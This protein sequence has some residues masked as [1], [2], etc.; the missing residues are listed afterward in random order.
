VDDRVSGFTYDSLGNQTSSIENY[1]NGTITPNSDDTIPNATTGA[2]TDL[3]TA[4]AYDTAGNQVSVA[5]P[6]RAIGLASTTYA[7]D[8]F[9]R[10]VT[11]AWGTADTG[12]TW[13]G[14]DATFD[15]GSGIGTITQTSNQAK[16][17]YLTSVSAQDQEA[18]VKVRVD[19]LAVGSDHLVWIYLR[20]QDSNN[21]YQARL[22]F[23]TSGSI[24]AYFSRTAS[25]TTTVIDAGTS[26]VPHTTS[27][28]YWIRARIAGT[29]SV[30]GK[31]KVW[32]D[33]TTEPAGW[34]A[35]GTDATPP[36]NLRGSG[37]TGIRF[38]LGGSYSGSYPVVASFDEFSLTSL[39]GGGAAIGPDDY[40]SRSTFDPLNEQVSDTTPTTPGVTITQHTATTTYDELGQVRSAADYD[41]LISATEYDRAGRATRTFEDPDPAGSAS[42]TS[43]TTYDA[44]GKTLTSEDRSQAADAN[45]GSTTT[46][47]DGLGRVDTVTSADGSSPDVASD[48]KTT[49]DGLDRTTS[50]EVGYGSASSQKTVY[51]YDL[52]GRT[53]TTDDGFACATATFDYRGLI[54]T[55]TDGLVG[56]TCASGANTRTV[57]NSFDGLG[58][59]YRAEVTAGADT[60]DRPTDLTLDSAGNQ[61]TAAVKKAGVTTTTTFT[62]NLLDQVMTEAR[63]DGSTAKT[64]YDPAGNGADR[65]YWAP[66]VTVGSC[67]EVGHAGWTNPPTSST[68]TTSDARNQRIGLVDSATNETTTYDPDHLY[69]VAAIYTPTIADLTREHQT[70]FS[71]DSRH[72]LTGIT[73]QLCVVST[74][75]NCSSTT[76]TGSDTYLY[77]DNNN[78]TKVVE[79]NGATSS[80]R[81]YC[82]DALNQLVYRNTGAACSAGA[83]DEAWTYDDAGNRLTAKTGGV[84]TNFAYTA[85]GLLCDVETAP[86]AASC[87]GGNVTSDS[88]GRIS[89]YAGWTY[90]Y[91]AEGRLVS[92]CKSPTCASGYDKVI[93]AYDGEGHRT[94]IVETAAGG[95]VTTTD[96]RYQ[97]DAVVEESVNGSVARQFTVDGS[98]RIVTMT[99]PSGGSAGTYI[100]TWNGHGDAMALWQENAD[101]SITLANSLTY[102]TWGNPT[103][104]VAGGFSDLGFRYQYVGA[105]DVQW[106]NAYGLGLLYM[107]ARHESPALGR[108]VEPD[109]TRAESNLFA[110]TA[111]AP[112]ARADPAGT[113]FDYYTMNSQ[114]D[115]ICRR[116]WQ[117]CYVDY[118]DGFDAWVVAH[119]LFKDR[120]DL[121]DGN[122][123]AL[124]HCTWQCLLTLDLGAARAEEWGNAHE[125]GA[126]NNERLSRLMDLHNNRVGRWLGSQLPQAQY[127]VRKKVAIRWCVQA[128]QRGYLRIIRRLPRSGGRLVPSTG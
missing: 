46:A 59:Q 80:D 98:G 120:R 9:G 35:D 1:V 91:D 69:Q 122:G 107:H 52:G 12:G 33:G 27:D 45:L 21:Y 94:K 109:P 39:G 41:A 36:A 77:D 117:A 65:C 18:L 28:W 54:L 100:V 23:N 32:R 83:N 57:T 68:S 13:S 102:G 123:D 62:V 10:T 121:T 124:R 90:G 103:T 88:A 92:A 56:G 74:G 127:S 40:V 75:H 42:V 51:G 22:S 24:T 44:D 47:Y 2:R 8:A 66:S 118:R 58:R 81:R 99:I 38:Q 43:V 87:T 108:F 86:T 50:T 31:V 53:L 63:A 128:M 15:V 60:G 55:A 76:A 125:D 101:G 70:L 114:E 97:G 16:S 3:T 105:S 11:D 7:R 116:D 111:N 106:D 82:Y 119:A 64:T 19:H 5:D 115:A 30:N 93:F 20:R 78:R 14:T 110:Y 26:S 48:T 79:D 61:L 37:H 95:T 85:E 112:I 126:S 73:Q 25:G 89:S 17:G 84:T 96:F 6:R 34:D 67:Y 71:Y 49:Y 72:R 104:T 4:Y 113:E 29:T